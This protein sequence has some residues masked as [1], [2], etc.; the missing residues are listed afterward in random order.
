MVELR[1]VLS[2]FYNDAFV[3]SSPL[4]M[5]Y[6]EVVPFELTAPLV[7]Q[8]AISPSKASSDALRL[9]DLEVLLCDIVGPES[10]IMGHRGIFKHRI[11]SLLGLDVCKREREHA[12]VDQVIGYMLS[13]DRDY[14]VDRYC[15]PVYPERLRIG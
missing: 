14:P 12:D 10:E 15:D 11:D 5:D 1:Q 9:F 3:A 4:V 2:V 13:V 6:G 8:T 7:Y